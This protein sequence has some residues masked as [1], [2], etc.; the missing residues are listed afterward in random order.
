MS[1]PNQK[2]DNVQEWLGVPYGTADRFQKA[3]LVPFDPN[4]DYNQ[5]GPAS[6]QLTD[7]AFLNADKG[8]SEDCL[9]L[10]IWAPDNVQ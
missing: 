9:N 2:N 10:N 6:L 5:S 3:Q 1:H 4:H 7:P 8:E